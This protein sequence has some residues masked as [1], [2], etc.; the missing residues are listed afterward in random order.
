MR[1][2]RGGLFERVSTEE[3]SRFGFSILDQKESLE[4]YNISIEKGDS[5]NIFYFATEIDNGEDKIFDAIEYNIEKMKDANGITA[6]VGVINGGFVPNTVAGECSFMVDVRFN[7]E[8][9]QRK[10]E[11]EFNKI[12]ST[13]Y[14][15]GCVTKVELLNVRIAMPLVERNIDLLNKISKIYA[16]NGFET[17]KIGRRK[18]GSDA[19]YATAYGIPCVDSL[20]TQGEYAHSVKEEAEIPSLSL[21][22]K[23]IASLIV[24]L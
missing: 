24:S 12:A 10:V 14:V 9:Q 21:S 20:G 16:K 6:N 1:I 19:A 5:S 7:N 11:E 4:K 18:G 3:Q 23:K 8:E 22:A 17:L 2:L 15:K 13:T